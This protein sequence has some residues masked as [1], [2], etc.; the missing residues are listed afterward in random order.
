MFVVGNNTCAK[1]RAAEQMQNGNAKGSVVVKAGSLE[2]TS[3]QV[4]NIVSNQQSQLGAAPNPLQIAQGTGQALSMLIEQVALLQLADKSGIKM[5]DDDIR[6]EAN[7]AFDSQ[8]QMM[9]LQLMMQGQGKTNPTDADVEKIIGKPIKD[10]KAEQAQRIEDAIKDP[11]KRLQLV[12]GFSRQLIEKAIAAR[13]NPSEED[14]KRQFLT[15][16]TKRI[17]VPKPSTGSDDSAAKVKT[18]LDE[19][20]KGMSFE[21]AI[22]RYSRD[23]PPKGKKLSE[24][25]TPMQG[26][27][28]AGD[29]NLKV[30]VKLKAG[31]VSDVLT[32]PGGSAAYKVISVKTNLPKDYDQKKAD[33]SKSYAQNAARQQVDKDLDQIKKSMKVEWLSKGY[34]AAYDLTTKFATPAGLEER[35]KM[36]ID[37]EKMAADASTG[38]DPGARAAS[39]VRYA[40]STLLYTSAKPDEKKSM[41]ADRIDAIQNVVQFT[42]GVDMRLELA[43]LE[44]DA[45]KGPEASQN[46][47]QAARMNNDVDA[48]AQRNFNEINSRVEKFKKAGLLKPEDEKAIAAEQDRWKKDKADQEKAEAERKKFEEED[49]KRAAAAKANEPAATKPGEVKVRSTTPDKPAEKAKAGK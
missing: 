45:K 38:T 30:L 39:Y 10:A 17:F 2:I 26:Q 34:E 13:T 41:A 25:T 14:V 28:L 23:T 27:F 12:A 3:D 22:D 18:A 9:K 31:D 43:D 16:E 32:V 37:I 47:L 8:I 44:A 21:A 5:S 49:R 42:D 19:V 36:M 35:K 1:T 4:E 11:A 6:K 20:K 15:V 7:S 40:I 46:L 24:T 33:Y 29:P 48:V